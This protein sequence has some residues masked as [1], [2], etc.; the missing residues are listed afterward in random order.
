[1]LR[2][3][4]QNLT[5]NQ[6]FGN[7]KLIQKIA[8]KTA[9]TVPFGQYEWNVMPFGIK[10]APS[11]FKKIMNDIFNPFSKFIIVYNDDVLVFSTSVDQHF[12]HLKVFFNIIKYNGLVLSKNNYSIFQINI[13]FLGHNIQQGTIVP[14]QRSIQFADKF[15]DQIFEKTQLQ[16]FLGCVNYI[17][18][19]I[20]CLSNLLKP[21]RYI[22]RTSSPWTKIHT[23]VIKGIKLKAKDLPCLSLLEPSTFKI[24]VTDDSDIGYAG[25]LKQRQT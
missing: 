4:S 18:D 20:P 25:I 23:N 7:F 6:A 8:I 14:I 3:F 16:Q 1:M 5:S 21:L 12:K 17:E 19:F 24:A 15:C 9:F 22:L 2:R 11:E 13:R 10:N